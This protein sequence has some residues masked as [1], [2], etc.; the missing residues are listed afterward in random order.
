M[1]I[2][3]VDVRVLLEQEVCTPRKRKQHHERTDG[4]RDRSY[5]EIML[6]QIE[7]QQHVFPVMRA[8]PVCPRTATDQ[9]QLQ[10]TCV[11]NVWRTI[12]EALPKPPKTDRG[13]E[14]IA[15]RH[16]QCNDHDDRHNQLTERSPEYRHESAKWHE[17]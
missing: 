8:G 16:N 4:M 14:S 6:N 11:R 2:F 12:H 1:L 13:A 5:P 9:L 17:E 7:I 3:V 10:R 15:T